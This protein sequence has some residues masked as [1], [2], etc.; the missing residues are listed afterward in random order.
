MPSTCRRVGELVIL[1]QN[2]FLDAPERALS[3]VDAQERLGLSGETCEGVLEALVDAGVLARTL[4]GRYV[5]HVPHGPA[6]G[7]RHAA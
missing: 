7:N 1:V 6:A 5:R 4:H 3:L 2:V